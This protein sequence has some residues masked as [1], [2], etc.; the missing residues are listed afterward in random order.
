MVSA[1]LKITD[2]K[3]D[4][5][6]SPLEPTKGEYKLS[7]GEIPSK[8]DLLV[9]KLVLVGDP[10]TTCHGFVTHSS[11]QVS[12]KRVLVG[13]SSKMSSSD[14]SRHL[15]VFALLLD[16]TFDWQCR[17]LQ[18]GRH[19]PAARKQAA[20]CGEDLGYRRARTVRLAYHACVLAVLP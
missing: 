20:M 7:K 3:T 17:P 18:Q 8:D 4:L 5:P 13:V 19:G 12:A 15:G 1:D 9:L 11:E 2:E 10:G 14:K 6:P 16:L